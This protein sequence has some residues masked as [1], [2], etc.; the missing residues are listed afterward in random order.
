MTGGCCFWHSPT[1]VKTKI[2]AL[3]AIVSPSHTSRSARLLCWETVLVPYAETTS[4]LP[5]RRPRA[6]CSAFFTSHERR[7]QIA[8]PFYSALSVSSLFTNYF[9]HTENVVAPFNERHR[10]DPVLEM[11]S[12][13]SLKSCGALSLRSTMCPPRPISDPTSAL[14]HVLGT[15]SFAL[16]DLSSQFIR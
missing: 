2:A 11:L 14:P 6:D 1:F 3:V 13:K 8:W 7:E 10:D 16:P 5:H 12:D 4:D 9:Y 15:A